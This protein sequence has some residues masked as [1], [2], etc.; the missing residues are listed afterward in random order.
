MT[1]SSN[2]FVFMLVVSSVLGSFA[3]AE[4]WKSQKGLCMTS[5]FPS[6]TFAFNTE[7]A[8]PDQR[9]KVSVVHHNGLAYAPFWDSAVV[10]EDLKMLSDKSKVILQLESELNTSWSAKDCQ[11]SGVNKVSCVGTGESVKMK[12]KTVEPWAFYSA[13]LKESSFAGDFN[14]IQTT[15][16]FYIDGQKYI[17]TA[18]YPESDCNFEPQEL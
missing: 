6:T 16:L 10:P 9:V 14:Y 18:K 8:G 4:I 15:L 11:W 12:S 5:P 1:K 17:Y 3:S 13:V 2:I 7:K